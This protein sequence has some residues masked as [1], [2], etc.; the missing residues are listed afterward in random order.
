MSS[1]KYDALKRQSRT[2]EALIEAKLA[3]YTRM[4]ASISKPNNDLEAGNTATER[5]RDL[6]NEIEGL[7]EKVC[8]PFVPS[9]SRFT[10]HVHPVT[11]NQ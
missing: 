5:W 6:E 1:P 8:S 7:I 11:R 9:I 4:A 2:L 3:S 10:E